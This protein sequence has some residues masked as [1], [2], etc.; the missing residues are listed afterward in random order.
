ME[1]YHVCWPRLTAKRVEPVVS[2][3]W[4]SCLRLICQG[5]QQTQ[6]PT[7]VSLLQTNQNIFDSSVKYVTSWSSSS[8]NSCLGRAYPDTTLGR[9]EV[10]LLFPSATV[11]FIFWTSRYSGRESQLT[12]DNLLSSR[13]RDPDGNY[14]SRVCVQEGYYYDKTKLYLF[15][16]SQMVYMA[17]EFEKNWKDTLE[18]SIFR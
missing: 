17:S 10:S 15:T 13:Y 9:S 14:A 18:R 5:Q 12:A 1:W 2:I 16:I 3:S 11:C 7:Y 8:V 6:K 4:A